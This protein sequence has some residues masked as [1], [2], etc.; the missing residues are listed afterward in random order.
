M[1]RSAL[2]LDSCRSTSWARGDPCV[3]ARPGLRSSVTASVLSV[4]GPGGRAPALACGERESYRLLGVRDWRSGGSPPGSGRRAAVAPGHWTRLGW[5]PWC[6]MPGWQRAS[7]S[8]SWHDR[9]W[10]DDQQ[11]PGD[12]GPSSARAR[13]PTGR[14]HCGHRTSRSTTCSSGCSV[15]TRSTTQPA[16][17]RQSMRSSGPTCRYRQC[18]PGSSPPA[19]QGGAS[20][21]GILP[22]SSTLP[23][24][25]QAPE[26]RRPSPTAVPGRLQL[27][28]RHEPGSRPLTA[29]PAP[30]R[31]VSNPAR[32][33][34]VALAEIDAGHGDRRGSS[35]PRDHP[36]HRRGRGRC[37]R[38]RP[39]WSP[40]G[41][42]PR[43]RLDLRHRRSSP[44]T[45]L[46]TRQVIGQ[47][48]WPGAA[49]GTVSKSM[50]RLEIERRSLVDLSR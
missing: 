24:T 9:S 50:V 27:G 5:C 16:R 42:G 32:R 18:G 7:A 41:A 28:R 40:R 33:D 6:S 29:P 31:L 34:R 23:T 13:R 8:Q 48:R 37:D 11:R 2:D 30:R 1:R 19:T 4:T 10:S 17:W 35:T 38:A 21:S 45:P 39:P 49:N 3:W 12:A 20:S 22:C 26:Q 43:S 44:G 15:P 47:H 36:R 46:G 14:R 25:P